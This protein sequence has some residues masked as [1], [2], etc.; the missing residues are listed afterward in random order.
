MA[1]GVIQDFAEEWKEI[2]EQMDRKEQLFPAFTSGMNP[3][4]Y[5]ETVRAWLQ[6]TPGKH[7]VPLIY[8]IREKTD[9]GSP[10][11]LA[12][13][14]CF[15]IEYESLI[16]EMIAFMPLS[17]VSYHRDEAYFATKIKMAAINSTYYATLKPHLNKNNGRDAYFLWTTLLTNKA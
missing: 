1:R 6:A 17:G 2:E 15:S 8:L 9:P 4:V 14:K 3:Q 13:S 7:G 16:E 10:P 12:A 5:D 11:P